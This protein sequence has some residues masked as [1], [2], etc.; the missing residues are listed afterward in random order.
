MNETQVGIELEETLEITGPQT[1]L[2]A[3]AK[4]CGTSCVGP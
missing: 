4:H 2:S 1:A 3:F